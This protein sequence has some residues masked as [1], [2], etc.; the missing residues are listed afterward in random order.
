[1]IEH[2]PSAVEMSRVFRGSIDQLYSAWTKPEMIRR[3][4]HPGPEWSNP[5]VEMN[6]IIGGAYRFGFSHPDEHVDHVVGGTFVEIIHQERLVYTWTWEPPHD[7]AGIETL[8]T[9]QFSAHEEGTLV[10][11][12]HERF[13]TLRLCK[14]HK[15]GWVDTLE[16]LQSLINADIKKDGN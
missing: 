13:P 1:M 7:D 12:K 16:C 10:K 4:L 5:L 2:N 14:M 9:V 3:W 8:V 15:D 11:L 6:L